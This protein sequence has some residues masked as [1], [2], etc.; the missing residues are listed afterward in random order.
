M[1]PT[2]LRSAL[3]LAFLSLLA[4]GTA[5]AQTTYPSV[6]LTGR[7]QT[8]FYDF[9]NGDNALYAANPLRNPE[10]SFLVRRARITVKGNLAKNISFIIQ[11]NYTTGQSGVTLKDAFVDVSFTQP[12]AK[13]GLVLRVG[14][15]KRFF[16]RYENTSSNNLPSL[17]R[18]AY[19]GLIPASSNDLA[20][21]NGFEAHDLGAGLIFTGLDERLLVEGAIMNGAL[22]PNGIDL[23]NSK[24]Y[25]ARATFAVTKMLSLGA[26][27]GDHDFIQ[28]VGA[29]PADS[30]ARNTGYGFDAAWSA[31]GNEGL[32]AM[33]DYMHGESTLNSDSTVSG[34]QGVAAYHIRMKS[35]TS[36]L[37]AIEPAFRYDE[38]K[39]SNTITTN[40][41]YAFDKSTLITAGVN[42][43]LTS[44][45]QLRLMY[46]SQ[47]FQESTLKTISGFR[48]ALTMH[49]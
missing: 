41:L 22:S 42:L 36:F 35:P 4:V 5:A 37:Y 2:M 32:Y 48:G 1:R 49:F 3:G 27:Y 13:S 33:V 15:F 46:E 44:R 34:V 29:L 9:N 24:S 19:R 38:A 25:Y 6:K 20:I 16:G 26:S 43:Y 8:E 7:L 12:E 31:P 39:P 47:S 21:A 23:N 10:S 30:S 11:P 45:S 14:Q 40:P 18:G 28:Q 17:E